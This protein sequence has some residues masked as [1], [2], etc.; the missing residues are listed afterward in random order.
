MRE[1]GRVVARVLQAWERRRCRACRRRQLDQM[2]DEIITAAGGIASFRGVP[3]P[4]AGVPP[5]P[6]ATC[7]SVNEEVVHG[8][9]GP[10][11]AR[12]GRH[13]QHRCRRDPGR[14]ARGRDGDGWCGRHQR[15]GAASCWT[16]RGARCTAGIGKMRAGGWLGD[17]SA[18]IAGV[19][20]GARLLGG[21]GLHRAWH[22]P[23][24]ARG[25][26]GA[27][28]RSAAHGSAAATGHDDSHRADGERGQPER[29][30]WRTAG[31]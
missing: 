11:G 20:R 23:G 7:I 29:R 18:A 10:A 26:P 5:Y 24:D 14:L 30:C 15:R 6:A 19:C 8:I 12:V 27:E 25:I 16:R 21:A 28:L 13:R 22:R 2:A 17:V 31:R 3:A 1:A 9:P 4:K